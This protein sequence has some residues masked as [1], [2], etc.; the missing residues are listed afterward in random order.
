[1]KSPD[2]EI[3]DP[4]SQV[5]SFKCHSPTV[6]ACRHISCNNLSERRT[7]KCLVGLVQPHT[8]LILPCHPFVYW[9]NFYELLVYCILALCVSTPNRVLKYNFYHSVIFQTI[10]PLALMAANCACKQGLW[11]YKSVRGFQNFEDVLNVNPCVTSQACQFI[12]QHVP[13]VTE[14]TDCH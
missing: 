3:A 6:F 7:V 5:A 13:Y 11:E 12:L 2:G 9:M 4:K 14:V 10:L 1:M 8:H